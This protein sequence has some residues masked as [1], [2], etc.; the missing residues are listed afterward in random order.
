V[1]ID[2]DAK[3]EV[4]FMPQVYVDPAKLRSFA[5]QLKRFSTD[6]SSDINRL[7]SQLGRLREKWRDQEYD[8][9]I[10]QFAS[11][12]NLLRRFVEETNKTVPLLEKDAIVIEEY[13]RYHL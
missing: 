9:F 5:Q 2:V 3:R 1:K 4:R 6:M 12:Q 10:R 13:Q 8:K 11:A 7:G